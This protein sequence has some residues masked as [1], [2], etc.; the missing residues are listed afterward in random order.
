M[1][2]MQ[3]ACFMKDNVSSRTDRWWVYRTE[4]RSMGSW[5]GEVQGLKRKQEESQ[6]CSSLGVRKLLEGFKLEGIGCWE[7]LDKLRGKI[8][9]GWRS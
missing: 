8:E 7:N 3:P 6:V 5:L 4:G 1:K 2:K 9:T